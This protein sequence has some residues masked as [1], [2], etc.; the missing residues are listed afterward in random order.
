V[1]K[2]NDQVSKAESER[3][4]EKRK[5]CKRLLGSCCAMGRDSTPAKSSQRALAPPGRPELK[6]GT[7][8][9]SLRRP[10]DAASH[11]T[12]ESVSPEREKLSRK[13]KKNR[14]SLETCFEKAEGR[15]VSLHTL[16]P[17]FRTIFSQLR[18][19]GWTYA[20][21]DNVHPAFYLKPNLSSKK[22]GALGVDMWTDA[23]LLLKHLLQNRSS[24]Y[25]DVFEELLEQHPEIL[26]EEEA[27]EVLMQTQ[28]SGM[29][30]SVATPLSQS[31]TVDEMVGGFRKLWTIL[32]KK[33]W[34]YIRPGANIDEPGW[35]AKPEV[36]HRHEGE[37]FINKW[38]DPKDLVLYIYQ[39]KEGNFR[40]VFGE[41]FGESSSSSRLPTVEEE[42]FK[43]GLSEDGGSKILTLSVA[44][45]ASNEKENEKESEEA[46]DDSDDEEDDDEEEE[47]YQVPK[48]RRRSS[49]GRYVSVKRGGRRVTN[50]RFAEMEE[51]QKLGSYAW[52]IL[53]AEDWFHRRAGKQLHTFDFYKPGTDVQNA[54]ENIDKFSGETALAQHVLN[55]RRDILMS[56]EE[57]F[58]TKVRERS[59][60]DKW[61]DGDFVFDR[62]VAF[63]DLW[64]SVLRYELDWGSFVENEEKK[65]YYAPPEVKSLKEGIVGKT[66]WSSPEGLMNH[67]RQNKKL[68]TLCMK[69]LTEQFRLA[70][71]QQM[72]ENVKDDSEDEDEDDDVDVDGDD[73]N[74]GSSE[75]IILTRKRRRNPAYRKKKITANSDYPLLSQATS[76]QVWEA[77][78]NDFGWQY[79]NCSDIKACWFYAHPNVERKSDGVLAVNMCADYELPKFVL[80]DPEWAP[81]VESA[82]RDRKDQDEKAEEEL[83]ARLAEREKQRRKREEKRMQKNRLMEIRERRRQVAD[84]LQGKV[85][86][87]T[88]WEEVWP[89]LKLRK[90]KAL[91]IDGSTEHKYV[92]PDA[93]GNVIVDA[94]EALDFIRANAKWRKIAEK[95]IRQQLEATLK[96]L[97][98]LTP[99]HDSEESGT[100]NDEMES[101]EKRG[102]GSSDEEEG[103]DEPLIDASPR[104]TFSLT[105]LRKLAQDKFEK[106][107]FEDVFPILRS[108]DGW[109]GKK[110]KLTQ[111][112]FVYLRRGAHE[113]SAVHGVGMFFSQEEVLDFVERDRKTY[114]LV[115]R[116]FE[117]EI[118]KECGWSK[119]LEDKAD[120][121][122]REE[123]HSPSAEEL[124]VIKACDMN[125]L[126]TFLRQYFGWKIITS[127]RKKFYAM[128]EVED[129]K[130][131]GR[132]DENYFEFV[133]DIPDMLERSKSQR[134]EIC[135]KLLSH[136]H[137]SKDERLKDF[138]ALYERLK[139]DHSDDEEQP[140]DQ[141]NDKENS[142]PASETK[143]GDAFEEGWQFLEENGWK[144][145][146]RNNKTYYARPDVR[147]YKAGT[148]GLNMWKSRQH[149]LNAAKETY[150]EELSNVQMLPRDVS[151]PSL[152]SEPQIA[153]VEESET[154][155]ER[156]FI[157]LWKKLKAQGWYHRKGTGL[158]SFHYCAPHVKSQKGH[159]VEGNDYFTSEEAVVEFF[160]QKQRQFFDTARTGSQTAGRVSASL[161]AR[162][163]LSSASGECE[164]IW[165]KMK[166]TGW[167]QHGKV[168][169]S[170]DGVKQAR[171]KSKKELCVDFCTIFKSLSQAI[172]FYTHTQVREEARRSAKIA[173]RKRKRSTSPAVLQE[174]SK[175]QN[176]TNAGRV[177]GAE[178][179]ITEENFWD[180]GYPLL[181]ARGWIYTFANN[182]ATFLAPRNERKVAGGERGKTR[183]EGVG[184][185]LPFLNLH[186]R[187]WSASK[188]KGVGISFDP[189]KAANILHKLRM[190]PNN[191]E[192]EVWP[193]LDF[194]GWKKRFATKG[195]DDYRYLMPGVES[196]S[197]GVHGKTLFN[198]EA[199]VVKFVLANRKIV[200]HQIAGENNENAENMTEPSERAP[201]S[202]SNEDREEGRQEGSED[203]EDLASLEDHDEACEHEEFVNN[204]QPASPQGC[205]M[206]PSSLRK[207]YQEELKAVTALKDRWVG[208]E[209][210]IDQLAS[211][212]GPRHLETGSMLIFGDVATGK[213]AVVHDLLSAL[214]YPFAEVNCEECYSPVVFYQR[215]VQ[216]I[217][218]SEER[219]V[220]SGE[221]EEEDPEVEEN[222]YEAARN[223][224]IEEN[225]AVLESLGIAVEKRDDGKKDEKK[226]EEGSGAMKESSGEKRRHVPK[227]DN[228]RDFLVEVRRKLCAAGCKETFYFVIDNAER[229]HDSNPAVLPAVL[230]IQRAIECNVCIILIARRASTSMQSVLASSNVFR[231]H[232]R[233]Y[234]QSELRR[235]LLR[236]LNDIESEV[237]G[238]QLLKQQIGRTFIDFISKVFFAQVKS[239]RELT[240][241][242]QDLWRRLALENV[243]GKVTHS[244]MRSLLNDRIHLTF[245]KIF[246]HD[247]EEDPR[248]ENL[249]PKIVEN[250]NLDEIK[251]AT[252]L[253]YDAKVVLLASFL[254][255][256]NSIDQ[257]A[258]LFSSSKVL[259]SKQKRRRATSSKNRKEDVSQLLLG[260]KVFEIE[261]LVNIFK[262]ISDIQGSLD[263][264][265]VNQVVYKQVASLTS[266]GLLTRVSREEDLDQVKL[267]TCISFEIASAIANNIGFN[268]PQFLEQGFSQQI[269]VL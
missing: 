29:A 156:A 190:S 27:A 110:T 263:L 48:R 9:G 168:F 182:Q 222:A 158:A 163:S 99:P 208:R 75:K 161:S 241:I 111:A 204:T 94:E 137:D 84:R 247:F 257:D 244:S 105:K 258:T 1:R 224:N 236:N 239:L 126:F 77:V 233:T 69:K 52:E 44:S 11:S 38:T 76:E 46:L 80:N 19:R 61:H 116:A 251:R 207:E 212:M 142:F 104:E 121:N 72:E 73:E 70:E 50:S 74:D 64:P 17:H 18:K 40:D 266:S 106:S 112:S 181:A 21:G 14:R 264:L 57:D 146:S 217:P 136:W 100:S 82:L 206:S 176:K 195:T 120:G 221:H 231:I 130:R 140:D 202:A 157:D 103:G 194:A 232:F 180:E 250:W 261:R 91:K 54:K 6:S 254:S 265:R 211:L 255:S 167:E 128:G 4:F 151:S 218:D 259:S 145:F 5:E 192:A 143:E 252:D 196:V 170:P 115:L 246:H 43:G 134:Q 53:R 268:L 37:A 41:L 90:W 149:A 31:S 92:P 150:L 141:M 96:R 148:L 203:E 36:K 153:L 59:A 147:T 114:M 260:P 173:G 228:L 240:R 87:T 210:E 3:C 68:K 47:I 78:R 16:K 253:P 35:Y 25:E 2:P 60:E 85:V 97:A 33:G 199:E 187:K 144:M 184:E 216:Q 198:S 10:K 225:L 237:A 219:N 242:S 197:Q 13:K 162:A 193:M 165:E 159:P 32:R 93:K 227:C 174:R 248:A 88:T 118:A 214:K 23:D 201:F 7:S 209:D 30:S 12:P 267:K 243:K 229:L 107:N 234:S 135:R 22:C 42:K 226:K 200:L 125:E 139:Y 230:R 160:R 51:Y 235:I 56:F 220:K 62:D 223:R 79:H 166:A 164:R 238:E 186:L 95:M 34:H 183:F 109:I 152:D 132:I 262:A 188:S 175:K 117:E 55:H 86:E 26:E 83:R 205:F 65:T 108:R 215:L 98:S 191:F 39:H 66:M 89:L 71:F 154:S 123:D 171:K 185:I 177:K 63:S 8:R 213:T 119:F 49:G 129:L 45:S 133:S 131:D 102:P 169:L 249:N 122:S 113:D 189:T 138:R 178:L 245:E 179:V 256:Y 101:D 15:K 155:S 172:A 124:Q 81:K 269:S 58:C 28:G 20:K 67:I 24:A 127:G